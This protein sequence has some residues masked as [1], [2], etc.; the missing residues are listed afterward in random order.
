MTDDAALVRFQRVS[1][2]YLW[3]RERPRSFLDVFTGLVRRRE[4]KSEFWALRELDLSVEAGQAVALIGANG[5][6]KSTALKLAS[7]VIEPT[8]GSVEVSGKVSA[9]LELAAGFHPDLTGR[10]NVFLS[11][12]LMGHSRKDMERRFD[13]IVDFSGVKDFID[14]PVRHYSSGM[15]MRLGFSVASSVDPDVLLIDEVLAVGD[16]TFSQRCVDRIYGLKEKGTAILF[17]SHDLESARGLCERA[18]LLER[19]ATIEDGPT[20]K[21]VNRYLRRLAEVE[22]HDVRR[23]REE[24]WGSGEAT[25]E[26]VWLEDEDGRPTTGLDVGK[27]LTLSVRYRRTGTVDGL[28][29]GFGLRDQT[30][31]LLS[32]PNTKFDGQSLDVT[33]PGGTVRYVVPDPPLLPGRYFVSVSLYDRRLVHAYDHWEYCLSFDVYPGPGSRCFGAVALAGTW[34]PEYLPPTA[35][36]ET[37]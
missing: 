17:V 33:A 14:N 36:A 4:P 32:G 11:G 18:V 12:A 6:G 23:E 5:A 7:R 30:G 13:D 31:Y 37:A 24:R 27:A 21:V 34:S 20:D 3:S 19:G 15:A 29:L 26:D 8:S 35:G 28:V 2:R 1:K 10:E 16:R 25:I 22:D 9:L